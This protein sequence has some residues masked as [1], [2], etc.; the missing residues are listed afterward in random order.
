MQ[1][2]IAACVGI[3]GEDNS[4][5]RTHRVLE[6]LNAFRSLEKKL[7]LAVEFLKLESAINFRRRFTG[8]T[9]LPKC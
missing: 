1:L 5:S 4:L 2:L 8:H 6:K 7:R 3:Q 9:P